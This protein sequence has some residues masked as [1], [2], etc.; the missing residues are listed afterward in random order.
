MRIL[1]L[2]VIRLLAVFCT[3]CQLPLQAQGSIEVGS[4]LSFPVG[5]TASKSLTEDGG[6][7]NR[8]WGMVV[9]FRKTWSKLPDGL[10]F[11]IH[12]S[13]QWNELDRVA[14][15][16]AY[17]D[18]LGITT[19]LSES[20]HSPVV[21]TIGP[22]YELSTGDLRISV[23][24]GV[25]MVI[26]NTTASAFRVFNNSGN[27]VFSDFINFYHSPAFTYLAGAQVSY[28]LVVD[29]LWLSIFGNFNASRPKTE[30][31]LA[32]LPGADSFTTLH[33]LNTGFKI[34]LNVEG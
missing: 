25:G 21:A 27:E 32:F 28:R 7:T 2:S 13:W 19:T 9:D 12:A 17:S 31:S 22:Y 34:V 10:G 11:L 6:F 33:F 14:I 15:Q 8:G 16:E 30:L 4:F 20:R 1:H 18:Y 24:G 5:K 26:N 29:R 23:E 3:L